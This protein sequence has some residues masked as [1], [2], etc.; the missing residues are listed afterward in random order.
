MVDY[1]RITCKCSLCGRSIIFALKGDGVHQNANVCESGGGGPH[2]SA[3]VR[4]LIFERLIQTFKKK[5]Y[6]NG[7]K[8]WLKLEKD[9]EQYEKTTI[10]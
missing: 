7:Q 3:N 2:A 4:L 9:Q 10:K 6:R 1:K 5:E 8:L